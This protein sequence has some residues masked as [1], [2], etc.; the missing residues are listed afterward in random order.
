MYVPSRIFLTKGVG[1]HKEKLSSFEMALRNAGIAA[2]N[3]VSVS[4]IY[5][6]GCKIIPKDEGVALINPGQIMHAVISKNET[7]EPNR[8]I[9][10][11]IGMAIP[12]DKVMYGYL[13]EHHAFGQTAHVAGEYAEDLAAEM[14]ATILGVEFDPDSSWDE[15]RQQWKISGKI[16]RTQGITQSARGDKS[17]L[18]TTVLSAAILLP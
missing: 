5:P 8:L 16:V 9:A 13:S 14:L 2:V 7:R 10:A 11:S 3:L 12:K 1:K 18:W 17:G 6:P 4:S 15:K